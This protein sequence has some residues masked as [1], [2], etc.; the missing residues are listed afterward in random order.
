MLSMRRHI[1]ECQAERLVEGAL[2]GKE[3]QEVVRHLLTSCSR[4]VKLLWRLDGGVVA[5]AELAAYDY[6]ATFAEV[7]ARG[8]ADSGSVGAERA[9]GE[10]QWASRLAPQPH[11]QRLLLLENDISL[12]HWG[13]CEAILSRCRLVTR[14][15]PSAGVA[16]AELAVA[17]SDR[18]SAADYGEERVHD[19]RGAA[20]VALGNAS[21]SAGDFQTA[22]SAFD[23]ARALLVS[24]TGDPLEEAS[25]ASGHAALLGAQ[26][27]F[28]KA[29]ETLH[30]AI[31]LYR[32]AG[33]R[34]AVGYTLLQQASIICHVEPERGLLLATRGL[35]LIDPEH[36]S[37]AELSGRHTVAHCFLELG[38]PNE[39]R[40]LLA[41]SRSAFD[42]FPDLATR[43]RYH[44]LEGAIARDL[45]A[46]EEAEQTFLELRHLYLENGFDF[47]AVLISLDL[48]EVL[49]RQ[50][51]FD[52]AEAL[53]QEAYPILEAW[54]LR[55]DTLALWIALIASIRE[56]VLDG[57][58][59]RLVADHLRHNWL[60]KES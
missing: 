20:R 37:Y 12:Q 19:F 49:L 13:V 25:L 10:A 28:E 52:E 60:S 55:R 6:S 14:E 4:C 9:R 2:S 26:G 39:A 38:R 34:R 56:R 36:D 21:R 50:E 53:I 51:R 35:A 5:A 18:L 15:S 33:D 7:Q 47:E 57:S 23:T 29:V 30:A 46:L 31:R 17:A 16:M 45:G 11:I 27:E 3:S 48:S 41:K 8:L 22:A 43:T 54:G 42:R 24:G 58:L 40:A 59:F 44:W 1:T 32:E